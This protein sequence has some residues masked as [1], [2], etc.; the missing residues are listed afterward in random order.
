VN[1]LGN[2]IRSFFFFLFRVVRANE[3]MAVERAEEGGEEEEGAGGGII[4]S[5]AG[6]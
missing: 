4:C 6:F 5:D 3:R 1:S 2:N